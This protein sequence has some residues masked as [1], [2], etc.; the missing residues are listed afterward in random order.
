MGESIWG[1]LFYALKAPMDNML[2]TVVSM[3]CSSKGMLLLTCRKKGVSLGMK[4]V[5]LPLPGASRWSC[6]PTVI[7]WVRTM[8]PTPCEDLN[9]H[10]LNESSS[11]SWEVC[12]Y[13]IVTEEQIQAWREE[14]SGPRPQK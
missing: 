7:Y 1:L 3:F 6:L 9:I 12:T 4:M 2:V 10:H 8:L 5:E 13:S 14:V 11:N